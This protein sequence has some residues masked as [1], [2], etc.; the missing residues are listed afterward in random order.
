MAKDKNVQ[1][2]E[3]DDDLFPTGPRYYKTNYAGTIESGVV[4][5]KINGKQVE[6]IDSRTGKRVNGR[7]IN[8]KIRWIGWN[9]SGIAPL[10]ARDIKSLMLQNRGCRKKGSKKRR[11]GNR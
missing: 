7:V 6:A 4:R 10:E 2:L 1:P 3:D 11:K 8:G 9:K 5:V